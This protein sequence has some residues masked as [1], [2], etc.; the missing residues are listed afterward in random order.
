MLEE[1]FSLLSFLV[2]KPNFSAENKN[3]F[4]D[5]SKEL[6]YVSQV[7]QSSPITGLE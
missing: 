3:G 2:R 7:K 1:L 4:G 6:D 5:L